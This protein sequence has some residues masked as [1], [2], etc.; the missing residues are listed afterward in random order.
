M[1]DENITKSG[2]SC[3]QSLFYIINEKM[4]YLDKIKIEKTQY[5]IYNAQ[6]CHVYNYDSD[7]SDNNDQQQE[8]FEYI[9]RVLPE[10]LEGI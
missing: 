4:G 10:K 5:D 9:N 3:F 8:E 2:F 7:D 6:N 1:E